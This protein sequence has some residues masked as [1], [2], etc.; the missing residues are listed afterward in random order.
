MKF[1]PEKDLALCGLACVL[2]SD[3]DCPGCKA[4]GCK[5]INDCSAYQCVTG[6]GLD[7]CYQCDEFP[8]NDKMLQG[9]RNR[10]FNRYAKEHGKH[11]L[12]SRLRSNYEEGITYHKPGGLK[13]DYDVP[14]TEDDIMQLIQYGKRNPYLECPVLET[15]NFIL[16]MVV[17]DDAADLLTC[18]SDPNVRLLFNSDTCTSNFCYETIKD[19]SN[20]INIWIECYTR[21]DFVRF[22]IIDK[23]SNKAVGS[24]EVFG[25][26]GRYKISRGILRLDIASKYEE[27]AYLSELLLLSINKFFDLFDINQIVTKA[28]PKALIRIEVLKKLGFETYD[29]PEREYYW[30]YS[31]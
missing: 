8:C 10:A 16:R 6:R 1:Y 31:H 19:M 27:E 11:K 18:Y 21:K 26:I 30:T 9:V 14:D 2:C 23:S 25:M 7:G 29:F 3:E 22:S 17:E 13:G 24:I 20:C 28:I 4:R 5:N 12:L 15:E